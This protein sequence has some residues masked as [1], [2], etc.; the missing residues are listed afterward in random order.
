MESTTSAVWEHQ[1][2]GRESPVKRPWS[3]SWHIPSLKRQVTALGVVPVIAL[4]TSYVP[5]ISPNCAGL[6]PMEVLFGP[7]SCFSA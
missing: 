6:S 2:R 1:G 7:F 4:I 5:A 3:I